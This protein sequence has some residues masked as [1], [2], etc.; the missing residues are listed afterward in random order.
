MPTSGKPLPKPSNSRTQHSNISNGRA[1]SGI[2]SCAR[3]RKRN[4]NTPTISTPPIATPATTLPITTSNLLEAEIAD[5]I[6]ALVLDCDR[7]VELLQCRLRLF[8]AEI[9]G[10]LVVGFRRIAVFRSAAPFGCEHA[11]PLQRA[12][13]ILRGRLLEQRAG[14]GLVPGT[15]GA[16]SEHQAELILRLR[17]GLGSLREQLTGACGIRRRGTAPECGEIGD[18]ARIAGIRRALEQLARLFLVPCNTRAGAI[19]HA[20]LHHRR[21][22]ALV[23]GLAPGRDR[24]RC[25]T[26]GGVGASE[27]VHRAAR[28]AGGLL[29][30]FERGRDVPRRD[31]GNALHVRRLVRVGRISC[32]AVAQHE[33]GGL[34]IHKP[35]HEQCKQRGTCGG[36]EYFH[37]DEVASPPRQ[38]QGGSVK[39][40]A[41]ALALPSNAGCAC[42]RA[43]WPRSMRPLRHRCRRN[44]CR[45]RG[46][47][48][49]DF[50]LSPA[51]APG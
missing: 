20:E 11:H 17:I 28:A 25:L 47:R 18:A 35:G 36:T 43:R 38:I 49:P 13:M 40:A 41:S 7:T 8:I 26:V 9:G 31:L 33:I 3:S 14:A 4:A 48:T 46:R 22:R 19:E 1:I 45:P 51:Y 39:C 32:D 50:P 27:L 15:A 24:L 37:R 30:E 5:E 23:C 16:V 12:R 2:A 10:A 44:Q 42:P 34:R 29:A 6:A 21:G